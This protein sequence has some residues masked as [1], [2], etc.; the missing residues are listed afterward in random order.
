MQAPSALFSGIYRPLGLS[1]AGPRCPNR[2]FAGY[3]Q[4]GSHGC[5]SMTAFL[6]LSDVM[7][8]GFRGL[9]RRLTEQDLLGFLI[10]G[11][12]ATFGLADFY[13]ALNGRPG[14]DR[15]EPALEIGKVI[16][17]LTLVGV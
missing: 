11:N 6:F 12:V 14:T 10:V 16:Q 13:P 3:G 17:V 15:F 8:W 1:N 5:P 4:T 7:V 9:A 2:S